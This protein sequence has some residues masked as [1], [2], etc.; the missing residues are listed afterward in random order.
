M[1]IKFIVDFKILIVFLNFCKKYV[2]FIGNIIFDYIVYI[3][4]WF[5]N[6]LFLKGKCFMC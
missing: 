6:V 5:Y 1:W 2:L 3:R 4:L